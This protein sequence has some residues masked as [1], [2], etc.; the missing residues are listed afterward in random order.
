VKS[1]YRL[2]PRRVGVGFS[3]LAS[4]SSSGANAPGSSAFGPGPTTFNPGTV[5]CPPGSTIEPNN[6]CTD[7]VTN[8]VVAPIGTYGPNGT[9]VAAPPPAPTGVPSNSGLYG[10]AGGSAPAS[11]N[12]YV[13]NRNRP[14]VTP[15][16]S[17]GSSGQAPGN[18]P[19]A[20]PAPTGGGATVTIPNP[21]P[22]LPPIV[23]ATPGA[24]APSQTP[25]YANPA[26]GAAAVQAGVT[27]AS[28]F[29]IVP[30]AIGVVGLGLIAVLLTGVRP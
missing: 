2:P 16:G 15:G 11:Q 7:N 10:G 21:T 9:I 13:P 14:G 1:L 4:G 18:V 5:V 17:T 6:T 23:V 25:T 19:F 27:T 28:S 12:P 3:L 26:S 8:A 20:P 22:G 24:P 29:P 30:V